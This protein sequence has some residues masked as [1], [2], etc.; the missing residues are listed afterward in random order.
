MPRGEYTEIGVEKPRDKKG[1][2]KRRVV[3]GAVME[4]GRG[5]GYSG[6][7]GGAGTDESVEKEGLYEEKRP[8]W[9]RRRIC[10]V[11]ASYTHNTTWEL[12]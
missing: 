1:G 4:E 11:P 10:K 3:S 12:C 8:W 6:L 5:K 9:K 2:L 7:R